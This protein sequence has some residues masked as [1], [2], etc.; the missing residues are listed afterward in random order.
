MLA[1][2]RDPKPRTD[3][4]AREGLPCPLRER[5]LQRE[6]RS[7]LLHQISSNSIFALTDTVDV[8][9][10]RVSRYRHPA[11]RQSSAAVH[12]DVAARNTHRRATAVPPP[13]PPFA[14]DAGGS[15]PRLDN[16]APLAA[17]ATDMRAYVR[18]ADGFTICTI[19]RAAG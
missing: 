7:A 11:S 5:K 17:P 18:R 4:I 10:D 12:L 19:V 9:G 14:I 15:Q 13:L 3:Q 16:A 2:P 1:A 8:R 6:S